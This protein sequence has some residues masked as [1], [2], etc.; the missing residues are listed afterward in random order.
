MRDVRGDVVAVACPQARA[1]Q[2]C[3]RHARDTDHADRPLRGHPLLCSPDI[4]L[5]VHRIEI[6]IPNQPLPLTAARFKH[7]LI[8]VM[9]GAAPGPADGA[10]RQ[11]W[12]VSR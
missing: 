5:P 4:V 9:S 3:R 10:C 12:E 11:R 7:M 2:D 8:I 6:G 1:E